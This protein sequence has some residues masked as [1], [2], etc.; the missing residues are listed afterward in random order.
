MLKGWI[1]RVFS[2][3]WAYGDSSGHGVLK[4]LGHLPI[5]LVGLGGADDR[6][7]QKRGYTG[8]MKTQIES[9]IFDYCGAQV[10]SSTLLLETDR[11][12]TRAPADRVRTWPAH[13][14]YSYGGSIRKAPIAGLSGAGEITATRAER[15]T[16]SG[17]SFLV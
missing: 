3:G 10:W 13:C 2:N 16:G 6:T 5:H 17:R 1:D 12:D 11:S 4:K 15:R 14:S 8:A 7:W 9:G